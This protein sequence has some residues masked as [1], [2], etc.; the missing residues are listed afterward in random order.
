MNNEINS[1]WKN[2]Y[3]LGNRRLI[4]KPALLLEMGEKYKHLEIQKRRNEYKD[5]ACAKVR[6]V[7]LHLNTANKYVMNHV[8]MYAGENE[9]VTTLDEYV[10][11]IIKVNSY[12]SPEVVEIYETIALCLKKLRVTHGDLHGKNIY[13]VVSDDLKWRELILIDFGKSRVHNMKSSN[14]AF[15]QSQIQ[16]ANWAKRKGEPLHSLSSKYEIDE[17][18]FMPRV[19][20]YWKKNARTRRN[21]NFVRTLPNWMQY[22]IKKGIYGIKDGMQVYNKNVFEKTKIYAKPLPA[23]YNESPK[24]KVIPSRTKRGMFPFIKRRT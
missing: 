8:N 20:S 2:G 13:V 9:Y 22:G 18:R 10:R 19:N 21:E 16:Y 17:E 23:F 1:A 12:L 11:K 6:I 24:E 14:N 5:V 4:E 3:Y 7:K 15:I